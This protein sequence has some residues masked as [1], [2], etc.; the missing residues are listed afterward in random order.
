MHALASAASKTVRATPQT[1][2]RRSGAVSGC[3][4]TKSQ[5]WRRLATHWLALGVEDH[6]A[7]LSMDRLRERTTR[8]TIPPSSLDC[9][10]QRMALRHRQPGFQSASGKRFVAGTHSP[11]T[12]QTASDPLPA[13]VRLASTGRHTCGATPGMDRLGRRL[14]LLGRRYRPRP[15]SQR[16]KNVARV[17]ADQEIETAGAIRTHGGDYRDG[18]GQLYTSDRGDNPHD[19]LRRCELRE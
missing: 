1:L 8:V 12:P 9:R 10:L 4:Q 3:G 13:A 17:E 5:R 14:G 15:G 6:H 19:R 7:G 16:S 18:A 2:C 11:G